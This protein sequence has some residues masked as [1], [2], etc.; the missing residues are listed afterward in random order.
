MQQPPIVTIDHNC[1]IALEHPEQ[2]QQQPIAAAV[3]ALLRLHEA[4]TLVLTTTSSTLLENR[5]PRDTQRREVSEL[6]A[7]YR[8]LGLG[9]MDHFR[10]P[11]PMVFTDGTG[12]LFAGVDLELQFLHTIHSLMFPTIDFHRQAYRQRYCREKGLE[13]DIALIILI[14]DAHMAPLDSQR[15]VEGFRLREER[16]DLA[17]HADRLDRK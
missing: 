17:Q 7:H 4:G 13:G 6:L 3:R 10:G 5:S 1:I 12:H 15:R 8:V 11:Q 9:T 2:V 14:G 16:P